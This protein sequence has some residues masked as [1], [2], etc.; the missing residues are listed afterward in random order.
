TTYEG[1]A[2]MVW[3][4][5]NLYK[6]P[7]MLGICKGPW[8]INQSIEIPAKLFSLATG[9]STS[10]KEL[11][12]TAQRVQLLERAF[13]VMRGIRKRDDTLPRRMFE[14]A[15]PGGPLKGER[16]DKEKFDNMLNE[17]YVISGWDREGIPMKETFRKYNLTSELEIF[18]QRLRGD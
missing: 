6:I 1:K 13:D 12:L 7:D 9:V 3:E 14:T 16:L 11:L 17:Y 2:L 18:K 15:V 10:E 4:Q 8:S 5:A